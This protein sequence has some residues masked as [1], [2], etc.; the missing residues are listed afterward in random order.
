MGKIHSWAEFWGKIYLL[1]GDLLS[2]GEM[3]YLA[4]GD[5]IEMYC[6]KMQYWGKT[7]FYHWEI[8]VMVGDSI[9]LRLII[10]G[11]SG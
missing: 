4:S 5:E 2:S 9:I 3:I 7:F 11:I 1:G 10:K 6:W 8:D